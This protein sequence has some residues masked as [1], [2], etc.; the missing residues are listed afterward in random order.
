[1]FLQLDYTALIV[2]IQSVYF[3]CFCMH[4]ESVYQGEKLAGDNSRPGLVIREA[5]LLDLGCSGVV[6]A[7][8]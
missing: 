6:R 3:I 1:M 5:L 2:Q 4:V 7:R 8:F